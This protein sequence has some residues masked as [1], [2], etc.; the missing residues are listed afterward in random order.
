MGKGGYSQDRTDG[1]S[2]L[3]MHFLVQFGFFLWMIMHSIEAHGA[4]C[5]TETTNDVVTVVSRLK[6][7]W[8]SN[9]FSDFCFRL[10]FSFAGW[11]GCDQKFGLD[12]MNQ[13]KNFSN[14]REGAWHD[15]KWPDV[16]GL[17]HSWNRSNDVSRQRQQEKRINGISLFFFDRHKGR[18]KEWFIY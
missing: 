5:W 4:F 15:K 9:S 13:I 11:F 1:H 3:A 18:M 10:E 6:F 14:V 7:G 12:R 17:H 8:S 2:S 16:V